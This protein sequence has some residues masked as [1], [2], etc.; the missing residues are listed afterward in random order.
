MT[1]EEK[2]RKIEKKFAF[3]NSLTL[4]EQSGIELFSR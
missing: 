3:A 1:D 2:I 4:K